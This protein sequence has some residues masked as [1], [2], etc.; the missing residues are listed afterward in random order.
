MW[1]DVTLKQLRSLAAIAEAGSIVQAAQLLRVT[2]PAVSQQLRLLE[3]SCGLPLVE[4]TREGLR[5]TGAGRELIETTERIEAEMARSERTLRAISH[6]YGGHVVFGAVSTAKYVAPQILAAF[7]S[8]HPDIDVEL[9]IGNR[10]E[11]TELLE[12]GAVDV[13]MMGRPPAGLPLETAMLG[14]HPHLIIAAPGSALSGRHGIKVAELAE[15]RFLIRERGSG[16]RQVF[17]E[18]FQGRHLQP[19]VALEMSSNETI[20]QAVLAGLG[21]ALIS[22]HTIAAEVSD[23][24]LIVLD[25]KGLPVMRWWQVVRRSDRHILP[26]AKA[27]WDFLVANAASHFPV[28][29]AGK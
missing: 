4:R 22:A 5:P 15:H 13:V 29:A 11:T 28:L 23:G 6:G 21:I 9:A 20:K 3:R 18:L 26:D 16:S 1:Q 17:E 25:V 24:R 12:K 27:M 7:W 19:P 14:P 10:D 8:Q 2:A